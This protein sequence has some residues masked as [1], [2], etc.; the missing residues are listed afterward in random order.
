MHTTY[1][2]VSACVCLY[3]VTEG[4]GKCGVASEQIVGCMDF[5]SGLGKHVAYVSTEN[6]E[7]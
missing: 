2:I 4:E 3:R 1:M 5:R 7:N 6:W